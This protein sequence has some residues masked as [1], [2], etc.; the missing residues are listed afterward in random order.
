M[1]PARKICF[2]TPG[3][4]SHN[5]RLVKEAIAAEGAGHAVRIVAGQFFDWAA[6]FDSEIFK[7]HPS[8]EFDPVVKFDVGILGKVS[9]TWSTVRSRF[10]QH[11]FSLGFRGCAARAFW[12]YYSEMLEKTCARPADLFVGH[13][14][15]A[16]PVAAQ[17]A[18]LFKKPF[19]FDLEDAHFLEAS[20]RTDR[21]RVALVEALETVYLPKAA[22]VTASSPGIAD[23]YEK[24]Y[25]LKR[26]VLVLNVFPLSERKKLPAQKSY[27]DRRDANRVSIYWFSQT[28][29]LDR[30][31]QAI[32][33]ALALLND[34]PVELHLR[35]SASDAVKRS[36]LEAAG[37]S[38]VRKHIYFH[39]QV[40]PT[41]LLERTAEHDIGL[42]MEE[43]DGG[44]RSI[45]ITN[46][47]FYYMITG[48]AIIAS[49]TPG[50]IYVMNQAPETG[51]HYSAG[52]EQ[53]LAGLLGRWVVDSKRL[54]ASKDAS[55]KA[56]EQRFNWELESIKFLTQAEKVL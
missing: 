43:P 6:G 22:F 24:R 51:F 31:L 56:A 28:I 40:S 38:P 20:N 36:L 9:R 15:A 46:K 41:E 49:D 3:H 33:R 53:A 54:S 35:G 25:G 39:P 42:A 1:S 21:C 26:P 44:N 11:L 17:A 7:E 19:A 37:N 29:G 45:C 18:A 14:L 2:V 34:P 12:R 50:Q 16:L 47:I 55:L 5:P 13:N 4:I 27:R 8:W 48:L 30:G 10:D 23:A 52:N 32:I